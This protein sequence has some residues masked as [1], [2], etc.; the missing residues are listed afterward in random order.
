MS[1]YQAGLLKIKQEALELAK[2]KAAQAKADR[3]ASLSTQAALREESRIKQEQ[4]ALAKQAA[5]EANKK[6]PTQV[7]NS[8]LEI[9]S[10]K[11][12]SQG[13]LAYTS[14]NFKNPVL[15]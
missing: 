15:L 10:Y 7:S 6:K 5:I 12:A 9:D 11:K 4:I 13:S 2:A 1:E 14:A 3:D 8:Q